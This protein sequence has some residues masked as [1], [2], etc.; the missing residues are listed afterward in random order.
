MARL[1][2][3]RFTRTRRRG[4]TSPMPQPPV[5]TRPA[6]LASRLGRGVAWLGA[7]GL[8]LAAA[9]ADDALPAAPPADA[10]DAGAAHDATALTPRLAC[11][12]CLPVRELPRKATAPPPTGSSARRSTRRLYVVLS[13]RLPRA[14][15]GPRAPSRGT[16]LAR[17]RARGARVRRGLA[18]VRGARRRR[19]VVS[20]RRAW[21]RHVRR[22]PRSSIGWPWRRRRGP[23]RPPSTARSTRRPTSRGP[24][25]ARRLPPRAVELSA[26][27]ATG[28][29]GLA[30]PARTPA[31]F[32]TC[33]VPAH[34]ADGFGTSVPAGSGLDDADR[35]MLA[36]ARPTHAVYIKRRSTFFRPEGEGPTRSSARSSRARPPAARTRTPPRASTCLRATSPRAAPPARRASRAGTAARSPAARRALAA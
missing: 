18:F 10:A 5:T 30:A 9:C 17:P 34:G 15:G 12:A 36:R 32:S 16:R 35:D 25:R 29:A 23:P 28:D 24:R 21:T 7:A 14:R 31:T 2:R 26:A 6:S 19:A 4:M 1:P 27:L 3:R 22:S 8:A 33:V 20:A 13:P 11:A